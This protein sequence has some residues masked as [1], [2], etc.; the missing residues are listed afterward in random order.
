VK[1]GKARLRIRVNLAGARDSLVDELEQVLAAHP[2][3]NPVVFELTR[4]GN[5]MARLQSRA[6]RAVNAKDELLGRLRE[7]CGAEAVT[8]E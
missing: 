7:I 8:L 3:E 4:P 1:G 5:F 6:P 2:G